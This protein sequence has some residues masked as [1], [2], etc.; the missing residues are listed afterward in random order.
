MFEIEEL[1]RAAA[2]TAEPIIATPAEDVPGWALAKFGF[3]A[4][5]AQARVLRSAARRVIL[6]CTRQWGKSTVT[7]AKA[8]HAAVT[9]AES[10]TVVV[11]PSARQSGEFVRKAEGFVR[12]L[13][14]RVRG[15]GDNEISLAF[16]N[17]SRIVGLPG[18]E[19]TVRG[20]SAVGL[21]LVDEAARVSDELYVAVRPMVAVSGGTMWLMSTPRGKRGF[22]Y[23]T[24]HSVGAEWERVQVMAEECPRIPRN[25][26]EE[27]RRTMGEQAYQQEYGYAFSDTVTAMFDRDLLDRAITREFA[28]LR[29]E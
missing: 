7:A 20:F 10:L 13:G 3:T 16:D 18:S 14:M 17:G 24:W 15:D 9:R 4:D 2:E 1:E 5:P 19:D 29:I 22:F 23:E 26:L 12:Q 25:F 27:E 21:L 11:S 28:P 6:N 8:V